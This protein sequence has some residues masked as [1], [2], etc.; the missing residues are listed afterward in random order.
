MTTAQIF[1]DVFP[2]L[3]RISFIAG[4]LFAHRRIGK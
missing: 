4:A 3:A 2:G 1:S